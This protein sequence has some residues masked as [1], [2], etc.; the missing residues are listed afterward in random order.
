MP[1][2]HNTAVHIPYG[3]C[4]IEMRGNNTHYYLFSVYEFQF[5]LRFGIDFTNPTN[6]VDSHCVQYSYP[7][8]GLWP[9]A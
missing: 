3:A 2:A 1:V 9:Q 5:N 4:L 7:L 6:P 8:R